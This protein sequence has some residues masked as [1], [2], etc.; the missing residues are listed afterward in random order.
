MLSVKTI[1]YSV[2]LLMITF[3]S[4]ACVHVNTVS[5]S[6]IPAQREKVVSASTSR[7]IL[8][9]LAFSSKFVDE[10]VED[11][12]AQCDGKIEGIMT[13]FETHNYFLYLFMNEEVIVK[14]FCQ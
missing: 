1:Q 13:K 11:L 9:G 4:S 5:I 7:F 3:L 10:A 2:L 6:S 12:R 14:G 8:F